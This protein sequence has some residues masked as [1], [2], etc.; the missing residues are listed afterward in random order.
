MGAKR[1]TPEEIILKLRE[2]EVVLTCALRHP[3]SF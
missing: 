2:A 1:Y 3:Q